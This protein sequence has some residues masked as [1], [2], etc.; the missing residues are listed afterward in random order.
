LD[1]E[2]TRRPFGRRVL[3][4]VGQKPPRDLQGEQKNRALNL[5]LFQFGYRF[6]YRKSEPTRLFRNHKSLPMVLAFKKETQMKKLLLAACLAALASGCTQHSAPEF[7]TYQG[8][9]IQIEVTATPGMVDSKY[10]LTFNGEPVIE[11]RS[12]AF[13]GSSQVFK[14]SWRG[15]D[16]TARATRVQN[17]MSSYVQIDVFVGG[18]LIETLTV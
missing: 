2:S 8:E 5:S 11:Q 4:L 16:V 6:S 18:Q 12:Q 15:K 9:R 13:G 3:C 7:A 17:L 10:V 14:G 1:S